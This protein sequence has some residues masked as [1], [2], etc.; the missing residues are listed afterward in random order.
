MLYTG[1]IKEPDEAIEKNR[2]LL[3]PGYLYPL[4]FLLSLLSHLYIAIKNVEKGRQTT[5]E[6]S[7]KYV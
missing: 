7:Q 2:V 4:L 6:K 1:H 3:H 5:N